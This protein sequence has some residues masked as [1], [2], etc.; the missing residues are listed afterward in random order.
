MNYMD[1]DDAELTTIKVAQTLERLM[2][3][4]GSL[5]HQLVSV[6]K[7]ADDKGIDLS[8]VDYGEIK[9]TFERTMQKLSELKKC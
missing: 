5:S 7:L 2:T 1:F 8:S 4:I 9:D 6:T 3:Y